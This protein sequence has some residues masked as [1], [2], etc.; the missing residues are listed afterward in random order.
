MESDYS[1]IYIHSLE[2][3]FGILYIY[4]KVLL[5][6]DNIQVYAN[7]LLVSISYILSGVIGIYDSR[8]RIANN[9]T[10]HMI[11]YNANSSLRLLTNSSLCLGLLVCWVNTDYVDLGLTLIWFINIIISSFVNYKLCIV[12][13]YL[14]GFVTSLIIM[15]KISY[16]VF[17]YDYQEHSGLINQILLLYN[18]YPIL[19]CIS[20]VSLYSYYYDNHYIVIRIITMCMVVIISRILLSL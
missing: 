6:I 3:I 15:I 5:N 20:M 7:I 12:K 2:I 9:E 16:Y 10:Q 1:M 8:Y 4:I 14:L 17:K 13:D 19:L 18:I 11:E